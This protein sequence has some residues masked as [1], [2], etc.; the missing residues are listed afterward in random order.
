[1]L[2]FCSARYRNLRILAVTMALFLFMGAMLPLIPAAANED[3]SSAGELLQVS[4]ETGLSGNQNLPLVADNATVPGSPLSAPDTG[5]MPIENQ[6][7]AS[8][9]NALLSA[10]PASP[11]SLEATA[12]SLPLTQESPAPR[13]EEQIRQAQ[14]YQVPQ[15]LIQSQDALVYSEAAVDVSLLFPGKAAAYSFVINYDPEC[16]SPVLDDLG[17]PLVDAGELGESLQANLTGSGQLRVAAAGA[18]AVSSDEA[19]LCTLHFQLLTGG[20]SEL[21]ASEIELY[22]EKGEEIYGV[23][24]TPATIQGL[25]PEIT[26]PVAAPLPGIYNSVQR[27][28]LKTGN[29][30]EYIYYTLDDSDPSDP[31]NP[32]RQLYSGPILVN[33]NLTIKAVTFRE[34]R[35]GEP[36]SFDY[37][38]NLAGIGGKVNYRGQALAGAALKLK[39]AGVVVNT[40]SSNAAGDYLFPAVPE[41]TYIVV[42]GGT[43]G[44]NQV[45]SPPITLDSQNRQANQDFELFKGLSI[46]GIVQVPEGYSPS[47]IEVYAESDSNFSYATSW[48]EMDGSFWLEGLESASAYKIFTRNY[49]GLIDAELAVEQ[50]NPGLNDLSATPLILTAPAQAT[51]SGVV[52]DVD[53]QGGKTPVANVWLSLYSPSANCWAGAETDSSGRY[54]MEELIPAGDY[55]LSYYKWED[56]LSGTLEASQVINEGENTLNIDIPSGYVINGSVKKDRGNG[57]LEPV[58]DISV[59]VSGPDWASVLTNEQG[60]FS[61]K[62]LTA[63]SYTL[64]LDMWHSFEEVDSRSLEQKT[65][66]L[67][68]ENQLVEH[69][70]VLVSGNTISGRVSTN[71]AGGQDAVRI[72]ASSA[73]Q[74]IYRQATTDK[75]G[76]YVIRGISPANDYVVSAYK[77][78]YYPDEKY[79]IVVGDTVEPVTVDLSLNHPDLEAGYFKPEHN[80]YLAM[81]PSIAPGKV[82]GF[83]LDYQNDNPSQ[84]AA[85]ARAEFTLPSGL[86]LIAGSMTLNGTAVTATSRLEGDKT[87]WELELGEVLAGQKGSVIFQAQHNPNAS[88]ALIFSSQASITWDGQNETIGNA[89]VEVVAVDINGPPFSQPG[90]F[91]VYG[92]C[93]DSA[94][95]KVMGKLQGSNTALLLGQ[96]RAEGKW[97]TTTVEIKNEGSYQLYAVAEKA[98]NVSNPSSPIT[99]TIKSNSAVLQDLTINA[100]WNQNVKSNPKIGIPAIAVSQGYSVYVDALFSASIDSSAG[101]PRL[102]FALKDETKDLSQ[103]TPE[104]F[105]VVAAMSSTEPAGQQKT[106]NGSFYIDYNLAGDLKAYIYYY[107]EGVWQLVPVVQIAILIDPSGIITDAH[108][109]QPIPGVRAECEYE[110]N[111]GN[112]QR[113]PAENFGQVNPQLTD[114]KGYYGWDVPAG[115]YRV[116]FTHSAYNTTISEVV[117]VPPPKT[118]LNLGLISLVAGEIPGI[119]SKSPEAGD[120]DVALD[121]E[122]KVAFSKDMRN[123]SVN[124]ESFTLKDNSGNLVAGSVSA[125]GKL[126]TFKSNSGLNAGTTYTVQLSTAIQDAFGKSL[127]AAEWSFTTVTSGTLLV[128]VR[129][130]LNTYARSTATRPVN[131]TFSGNIQNAATL[132]PSV[133]IQII[134]QNNPDV[135]LATIKNVSVEADG[136]FNAS[137]PIPVI[138]AEGSYLVKVYYDGQRWGNQSF[139]V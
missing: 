65:I 15:L 100:G 4:E 18:Q 22:D 28:S 82:L 78:P 26:Q 106:W 93:A 37:L 89:Q 52:N 125:T 74:N 13:P 57:E 112:W 137:W 62:R 128:N 94:L 104:D 95:V 110:V 109:G 23:S 120:V 47:D 48:T 44:F 29:T 77:W 9:D 92:K 79:D 130:Q 103:V 14:F 81:S 72:S 105:Q 42:A 19:R 85:G 90:Q 132:P 6:A 101:N 111:E 2:K 49:M 34:G 58:P 50:L 69:N 134:A 124:E 73:S 114:E 133:D 11:D 45:E 113:W 83:R 115:T 20:S 87:V 40:V 123:D 88:T 38:I 91:T 76:D 24:L 119:I 131:V 55:Y 21:T 31:D 122:V 108:S 60:E 86:E 7:L 129:P 41:G 10:Q 64:E 1:M 36:A 118:D 51:L 32:G 98:G 59:W 75:Y 96:A 70:I 43:G 27:V 56:N 84:S 71:P 68:P 12:G 67:G 35:Y 139:A 53:G 102:L 121:S 25:Y 127:E 39:K 54:T 136:S 16:V 3:L 80:R 63:G 126:F 107:S 138:L 135:A 99:V 30:Q 117:Y 97:W 17:F 61:I 116:R 5:S 33:R 66:T 8:E 46:K